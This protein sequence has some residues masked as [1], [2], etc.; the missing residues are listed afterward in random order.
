MYVYF[1]YLCSEESKSTI[2]PTFYFPIDCPLKLT[3]TGDTRGIPLVSAEDI[4]SSFRLEMRQ[5]YMPPS[6]ENIDPETLQEVENFHINNPTIQTPLPRINLIRLEY[7]NPLIRPFHPAEVLQVITNFKNKAPGPDC[8]KRIHLLK[9]PK[10]YIVAITN[11]FNYS[12]SVG[13]YPEKFKESLMI[14]IA[15][16]NKDHAH[17]KNYRPISLINI[18]GKIY[19][20]LLNIRLTKHMT[21][22]NL[23]DPVQYGFRKGRGTDTSLALSYEYI[24]HKKST[25]WPRHRV[26]VVSRD[27]SGAL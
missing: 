15:K 4:E 2:N 23:Y 8:I 14:F 18:F 13:Y 26:S 22:N 27:I 21:D 24:S 9:V 16:P 12:L 20:K 17:P 19:G 6:P 11:I 3:N 25:T 5:R 1:D 7:N 10:I